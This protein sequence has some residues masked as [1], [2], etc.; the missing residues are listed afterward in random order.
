MLDC[1]RLPHQPLPRDT[2]SALA[3][4]HT[5]PRACPGVPRFGKKGEREGE[6][7]LPLSH[8][9]GTQLVHASH[10]GSHFTLPKLKK[11]LLFLHVN[12]A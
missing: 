4:E 3:P 11:Y 5:A 6:K 2:L 8:M 10:T 12:E 1:G 7:A 9:L